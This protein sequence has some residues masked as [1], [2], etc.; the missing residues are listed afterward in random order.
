MLISLT[1]NFAFLCNRKYA[2]ISIEAMLR[3][4]GDISVAG[5]PDLRHS[6]YRLYTTH[7]VPYIR[8]SV[9]RT[10]LETVCLVREPISWLHSWYRFRS[11]LAL[12][13][14]ANENHHKSTSGVTFAEFAGA[15]VQ[16]NPPPFASVGRQFDFV[17]TEDN[18]I[19]VD[20]IFLY[21]RMDDFVSFMSERIGQALRIGHKNVSPR[22]NRK[23]RLTALLDRAV[24]TATSQFNL[25]RFA[26]APAPPPRLSDDLL[27]AVRDFMRA[28][29]ALYEQVKSAQ[30]ERA[31]AVRVEA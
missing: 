9:G 23:F 1:H 21:E 17:R 30:E 16:P 7:F 19:G 2:S 3:K 12:R 24:K 14:P 29:F 27:G 20:R 5:P 31:P 11:R 28:D 18:E 4:H 26:A 8:E 10:K 6:N 25:K 22:T 15:Y 13:D